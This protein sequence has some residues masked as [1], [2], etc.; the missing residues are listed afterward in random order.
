MVYIKTNTNPGTTT[1]LIKCNSYHLS[2]RSSCHSGSTLVEVLIAM[3]IL[4]TGMLAV[5]VM[6]TE[7][8]AALANLVF[9][10][11]AV[12]LADNISET[13]ASLP[14]ELVRDPPPPEEGEC[15]SR[16]VCTP[17]QWLADSLYSWQQLAQLQLPDGHIAIDTSDGSDESTATSI[18][19]TWAHRNGQTLTYTLQLQTA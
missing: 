11:R 19:I 14:R 2:S 6:F 12:R 16:R 9:Q 1:R 17:T 13:L 15:D 8:I 7:S 3:V 10:Q 18:L 4:S 5:S